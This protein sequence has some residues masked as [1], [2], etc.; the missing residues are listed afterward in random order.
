[1]KLSPSNSDTMEKLAELYEAEGNSVLAE[2]YRKKIEV[3][4]HNIELD[5]A[6]RMV[7]PNQAEKGFFL[8]NP[9][10]IGRVRHL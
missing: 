5:K 8:I 3:V 4:K 7:C 9:F 10:N 6:E 1:M 2:K